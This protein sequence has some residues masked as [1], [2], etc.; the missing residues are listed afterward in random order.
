MSAHT[1]LET[2]VA[3]S[4]NTVAALVVKATLTMLA[5][6]L[7]IRLARG[8][9][10]SLRHLL[11]A[12]SF[13][14][15]LLLPLAG[16]FVPERT[17]TVA[18][19]AAAAAPRRDAVARRRPTAAAERRTG[20]VD[21][22][23]RHRRTLAIGT[24]STS[25]T[26]STSSALPASASRCSPGSAGS[27]ACAATP[28]SRS[29]V[30]AW[31]TRPRVA[32]ACRAGSR[33]RSPPSS[34]CPSPSAGRSPS[35]SFPPRPRSGRPRR[36]QRAIRHELEHIARG[37]WATHILVP[38]RPRP[39]LAAPVRVGAVA[40]P[41]AGGGARLRRR[42]DPEPGPGRAVRRA[43]RLPGPPPAGP[44]RGAGAVDGHA[45]HARA[46]GGG[47]PRRSPAA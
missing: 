18:P 8:A 1:I 28:R 16:I 39:L 13:G 29:P 31:P 42:R 26:A 4:G 33:S 27:I 11:A 24:P 36:W 9:S 32:R 41:A 35:S 40:P 47:H 15:L 23:R 43:A 20:R 21:R 6:L 19:A 5:A 12:A 30:R 45:Q 25:S 34:R 22:Q 44:R 10:A 38:R 37:D 46:A 7:L 17:I 3:A 2:L 14:V